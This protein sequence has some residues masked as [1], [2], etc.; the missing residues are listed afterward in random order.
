MVY[1]VSQSLL[2]EVGNLV[3]RHMGLHFPKNRW[4]ELVRGIASV[5]PEFGFEDAESCIKWLLSVPLEKK[6]IEILASHLTIG[7]TYFFREQ[8]PLEILKEYILPEL[9]RSRML[10]ERRLRIWSAACSTGEEAYSIAILLSKLIPDI[11]NWQI[12]IIGTDINPRA[13][14]KAEAGVYGNWSFR[15]T[16]TWVK[17]KYFVRK[18]ENRYEI[19]PSIKRLVKFSYLNLVMDTYPSP[20]NGTNAIDLIFCRNVLMYFMPE[21]SRK[22]VRQLTK[23]LTEGGWLVTSPVDVAYISATNFTPV[24]FKGA[25]IYQKHKERAGESEC[26]PIPRETEPENPYPLK[27][28]KS[29]NSAKYLTSADSTQI[30][31]ATEVDNPLSLKTGEPETLHAEALSFYEKGLYSEAADKASK[32]NEINPKDAKAHAVLARIYA[33]QGKLDESLGWAKKAVDADK[34][35]AEFHYFVSIIL[36]EQGQIEEAIKSL[37]RTLYLDS[38]F[39]QAYFD[40]GNLLRQQGSIKESEK[41]FQNALALLSNYDQE[42]ILPGS[43]GMNAGRLVEIITS[44]L[45]N[46]MSA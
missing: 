4:R 27:Y 17:E 46:K 23:C 2:E 41:Y 10:N 8:R 33:D 3:S 44:T 19:I 6:Q 36:Q 42:E 34:T 18:D 14:K 15:G 11:K 32:L 39:V 26:L 7:E 38:N 13:L 43:G 40:T 24:R 12:T 5:A 9:I 37:K 29:T 22:I 45:N 31:T 16:P 35:N 30:E 28:V 1:R 20:I 21:Q 25:T